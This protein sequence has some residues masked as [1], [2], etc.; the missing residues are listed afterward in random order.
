MFIV[1]IVLIFLVPIT[2]LPLATKT[3]FTSNELKEMGVYLE[4]PT[5]QPLNED[6]RM[7]RSNISKMQV[8]CG[9]S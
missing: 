8:V 7:S 1:I 9:N 5:A 6:I 4:N 2:F 3:F